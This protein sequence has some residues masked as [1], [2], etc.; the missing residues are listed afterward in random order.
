MRAKEARIIFAVLVAASFLFAAY[1]FSAKNESEKS[2]LFFAY[3]ANLDSATMKSR[4][5]GFE[6]VVPARLPGFRLAFQ[7]NRQTEFGVANIL[8]DEQGSVAGALYTLT[9]E[10]IAALDKAAGFPKF[11]GKKN[12]KVRTL[13]GKEI[14]AVAYSLEGQTEFAAPSRAY[15]DAVLKGLASAGYGKEEEAQVGEAVS[16]AIEEEAV[17]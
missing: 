17:D 6:S 4:A 7:T 1:V 12:V 8:P 9:K 16:K 2:V 15:L 3:G 5:G 11:Y 13:D 14:A 10:Q